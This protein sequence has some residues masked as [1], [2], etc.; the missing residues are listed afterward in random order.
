MSKNTYHRYASGNSICSTVWVQPPHDRNVSTVVD[1]Q[2]AS[3][4]SMVCLCCRV[5]LLLHLL[6]KVRL[7]W[8]DNKT[9]IIQRKKTGTEHGKFRRQNSGHCKAQATVAQRVWAITRQGGLWQRRNI[10]FF[11]GNNSRMGIKLRLCTIHEGIENGSLHWA[12]SLQKAVGNTPQQISKGL[13][14]RGRPRKQEL[15]NN[16]R[17]A[18]GQHDIKDAKGNDVEDTMVCRVYRRGVTRRTRDKLVIIRDN[19]GQV[20]H[21]LSGWLPLL[22]QGNWVPTT[23]GRYE[24]RHRLIPSRTVT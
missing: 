15:W 12:H 4:L 11:N 14:G 18:R 9:S 3:P 23:I 22:E 7:T 24:Q 19:H 1:V 13:I 17:L 8:Q 21:E 20:S 2:V 6:L 16:R 5:L 10:L